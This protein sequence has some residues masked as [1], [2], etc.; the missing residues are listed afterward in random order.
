MLARVVYVGGT[1]CGNKAAARRYELRLESAGGDSQQLHLAVKY[2]EP[3]VGF[4]PG[5]NPARIKSVHL[6]VPEATART[7]AHAL[8]LFVEGATRD[9]ISLQIVESDRQP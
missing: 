2:S 8:L 7:L 9:P 3:A 5:L 6:Q 4:G 1:R